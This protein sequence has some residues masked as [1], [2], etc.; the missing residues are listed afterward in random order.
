VPHPSKLPKTDG[1]LVALVMLTL[2]RPALGG[3]GAEWLAST[4][5]PSPT[6]TAKSGVGTAQAAAEAQVT[7]DGL[8]TWCSEQEQGDP[9]TATS[10]V[11]ACVKREQ[12]QLGKTYRI[13]AD[14]TVGRLQALDGNGY[15]LDGLWDNTDVGAGRTRW[16]GANGVVGRDSA[17]GGLALAQQWEVL[18]PG[19]VSASVL[20]RARS[21]PPPTGTGGASADAAPAAVCGGDPNCTEVSAFAVS[22]VE[23]RASLQGNYKLLTVTLRF[24]NKLGRQLVLGYVP[25]SGGATDDRGNRYVVRDQDTRGIGYIHSQHQL[26]DKFV[27]A[28]GQ[29]ADARFGLVWGGQQLFGNT[30]DLDLTVREILPQGN[31]QATL[32][33]EYPLQ[34]VGLV[35]G[36]GSRSGGAV[37]QGPGTTPSSAPSTSPSTSPAG[38]APPAGAPPASTPTSPLGGILPGMP[39]AP[40]TAG[41]CPTGAAGCYDAGSFTISVVQ[42]VPAVVGGRNQLVRFSVR[43]KNQTNQ[44]LALAYKAGSSSAVDDQGAAYGWGRPGTHDASVQGIGMLEGAKIDP[45]FQLPPG[46]TRDA[47]LSVIRFDAGPKLTARSYT[48]NTVLVEVRSPNGKQWQQVREYAIRL[49]GLGGGVASASGPAPQPPNPA[50]PNPAA[51]QNP[52][53]DQ[54]QKATDLLKGLLGK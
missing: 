43:V 10:R 12:G 6:V 45:Q 50:A 11:N 46:G 27:I 7:N 5:G 54:M 2:A 36:A 3:A 30:F 4:D 22:V 48:L 37:A 28:P 15:V 53:N 17:S 26:D 1:F 40:T 8:R 20:S 23:F 42:T 34:I 51:A 38:G 16:R 18:C 35:D 52:A 41:R 33:P 9:A 14:C 47:A 13:G 31:G 21:L 25:A 29:T 19:R 24:R 32:G 44:P 49:P 39:A